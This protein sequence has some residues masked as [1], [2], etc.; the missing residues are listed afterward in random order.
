MKVGILGSPYHSRLLA[1]QLN[2]N[3]INTT[4]LTNSRIVDIISKVREIDILHIY[5]W[6]FGFG[7]DT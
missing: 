7:M 3:G 1:E 2:K 4:I 5:L 6:T